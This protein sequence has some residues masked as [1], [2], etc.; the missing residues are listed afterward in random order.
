MKFKIKF[1]DQIVGLFIILSLVFL[2]IIVILL[3]VNQRWFAKNYYFKTVFPSAG[4][5]SEGTP[6]LMK[7]FPVGKISKIRLNEANTVDV[8]FYI[9]DTYYD[10]V[11]EYSLL[12]LSVSPI[13][14]GTQLLFLPG[15]GDTLMEEGSFIYLADSPEGQ[16]Y[17]EQGLVDVPVKDDT[18]TRLLSNINP[19]L[20]NVNKTVVTVNRTLTEINRALAGQSTGPLGGIV[21]DIQNTTKQFPVMMNNVNEVIADIEGRTK[22]LMDQVST[23]VASVNVITSNFEATSEALRDPTGLIPKL[24]GDKNNQLLTRINSITVEIEKSVKSL[25]S[26]ISSLNAEVP[27]I[28]AMLNETRIAIQKAQDVLEGIKNNPL[29]KGGIPERQEQQSLYQSMREGSIE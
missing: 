5:I 4:S 6:I 21:G 14:L 17:I 26:I 7:G 20:E 28:A 23:L 16:A 29:I 1:A 11:K 18:I 22:V 24:L 15:S 2:S 25:Q 12:E 3:G 19:L 13:G 27:K 9:Y 10:K 8:D